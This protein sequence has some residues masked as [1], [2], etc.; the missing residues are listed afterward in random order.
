[1]GQVFGVEFRR[2]ENREHLGKPAL[3]AVAIRTYDTTRSATQ[4]WHAER[5]CGLR[6]RQRRYR[7]RKP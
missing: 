3:V 1:M 5:P 7:T 4:R 6:E 2:V